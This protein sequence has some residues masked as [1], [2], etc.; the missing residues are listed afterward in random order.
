MPLGY[1]SNAADGSY[2]TD[3]YIAREHM[4]AFERVVDALRNVNLVS[5]G[6]EKIGKILPTQIANSSLDKLFRNA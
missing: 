6:N 2:N 3:E 1:K 4:R 5:V